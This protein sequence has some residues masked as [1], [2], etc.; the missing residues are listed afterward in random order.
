MLSA[1]KSMLMILIESIKKPS[2]SKEFDRIAVLSLD[3]KIRA[4][5]EIT[6]ELEAPSRRPK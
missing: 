2:C 5:A 3:S 4:Q 1:K 6:E